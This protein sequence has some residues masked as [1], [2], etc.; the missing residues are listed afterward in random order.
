MK[1]GATR[2][3][4]TAC[5]FVFWVMSIDCSNSSPSAPSLESY[6]ILVE[7]AGLDQ[8]QQTNMLHVSNYQ[9]YKLH[10]GDDACKGYIIYGVVV[11]GLQT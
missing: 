9:V 8:R 3:Q 2:A 4:A 7:H 1:G 10:A 6:L 11:A 5:I